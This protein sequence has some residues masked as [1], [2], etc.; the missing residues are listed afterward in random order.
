MAQPA[1]C[2]PSE[3]CLAWATAP[4]ELSWERCAQYLGSAMGGFKH[5]S[6]TWAGRHGRLVEIWGR[7]TLHHLEV[8]CEPFGRANAPTCSYR[9]VVCIANSRCSF[10]QFF[11]ILQHDE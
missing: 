6:P 2:G 9:A 1:C 4:G 5:G 8:L 11:G 10:L 7:V 3:R